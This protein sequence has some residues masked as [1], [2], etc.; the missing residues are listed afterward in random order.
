MKLLPRE[1]LKAGDGVLADDRVHKLAAK[2]AQRH[3][4]V[5]HR[6]GSTGEVLVED[7][8]VLLLRK[9]DPQEKE[10]EVGELEVVRKAIRLQQGRVH[11]EEA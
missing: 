1:L 9:G 4:R 7:V 5:L 6:E 10:R 11:D 8:K 2:K 3:I